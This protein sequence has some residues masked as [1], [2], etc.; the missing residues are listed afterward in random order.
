MQKSPITL[1]NFKKYAFSIGPSK[2][3]DPF[4]NRLYSVCFQH[5][6]QVHNKEWMLTIHE[7]DALRELLEKMVFAVCGPDGLIDPPPIEAQH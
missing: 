4:G 5:V 1:P 2:D 7:V 6:R 3:R